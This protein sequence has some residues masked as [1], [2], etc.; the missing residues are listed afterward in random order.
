MATAFDE[1]WLQPSGDVCVTGVAAQVPFLRDALDKAR[2]I[3]QVAQRHEYKNAA[4]VFTER[5]FTAAHREATEHLV[6]SVMRQ[7]VDGIAQDRGLDAAP[8][9]RARR[10]GAAFGRRGAQAGLVDR[11]GYRDEVYAAVRDQRRRRRRS[12]LRRTLSPS[13]ATSLPTR[14]WAWRRGRTSLSSR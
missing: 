12:A 6:A 13:E 5:A 9:P 4:N 14:G 10:P 8:S 7:L 11:L 1:I 2:I 3:P